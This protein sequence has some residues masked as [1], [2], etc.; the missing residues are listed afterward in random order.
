MGTGKSTVAKLLSARLGWSLIDVDQEIERMQGR[1]IADIFSSEGEP[2][3]RKAET[4]ALRHV[5]QLPEPA[6][7]ATGGGAVLAEENR[8][9]MLAGGFVAA[10]TASEERII[11]RV[12]HDSARPLLHGDVAGN[13]RSLLERRRG[14]YDFAHVRVDTDQLD[15]SAVADYI[16]ARV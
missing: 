11:E 13:V 2:F 6:V 3:F 5:L 14:A 9:M 7:I 15:P 8:H 16:L 10:L 1:R 4:E 12:M